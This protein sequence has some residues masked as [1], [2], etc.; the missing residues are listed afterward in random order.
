MALFRGI[1]AFLAG[2]TFLLA[3]CAPAEAQ[4]PIP[5]G[6]P[7]TG[8]IALPHE[9]DDWTVS[10]QPGDVLLVRAARIDGTLWPGVRLKGS[11]GNVIA[12]FWGPVLAEQLVTI[13]A[14]GSGV[15]TVSVSDGYNDTFTGNYCLWIQRLNQPDGT[16][17]LTFGSTHPGAIQYPAQMDTRTFTA[18]AGDVIVARMSNRME[19]SANSVWPMMRIYGLSGNLVAEKRGAVSED[20]TATIPAPGAYTFLVGDGFNGTFTGTYALFVQRPNRP[21]GVLP[22]DLAHATNGTIEY[23]G[24]MKT[25]TVALP[26]GYD[27]PLSVRMRQTGGKVWPLLRLY[28]PDG[29]LMKEEHSFTDTVLSMDVPA[30]RTYT[31]LLYTSRCV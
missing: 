13:P 7:I 27:S 28:G 15:V 30:G 2:F 12:D 24:T 20:L 29:A 8:E 25:Y 18:E 21:G 26:E 1:R 3:L 16:L 14:G 22:L 5:Y 17:P 9:H 31:C 11:L 23:P 19:S 6:E 4:H 10:A